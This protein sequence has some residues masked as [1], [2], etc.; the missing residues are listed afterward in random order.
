MRTVWP[1]PS[2]WVSR[3]TNLHQFCVKLKHSSTEIIWMI[4]KSTAMDNR[5]LAASSW[6]RSCSCI[7]CHAIFWQNIPI[8]SNHPGYSAPLWP[9]FGA[10]QLL[11]FPKT[12]ITF[13]REEI[14]D[15]RW[16]PGKY[17]KA[18]DGDWENCVKSQGAYF[19]GD[20]GTIVLCTMSLVSC[21]F[22]NKCL[23]FSYYMAGNLLDRLH[24][25]DIIYITYYFNMISNS[26]EKL[27][28]KAIPPSPRFTSHTFFPIC[29][30]ILSLYIYLYLHS[31]VFWNSL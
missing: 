16:N 15:C 28:R 22:F 8:H 10:L 1:L 11:A 4:Q 30:L 19:E 17:N 2:K 24:I 9:R 13:E 5:W 23:Y 20:W 21:I 29:F 18:A 14:S 26:S 31:Y 27:Q 6:P 25:Y 7:T 3:A 12:K